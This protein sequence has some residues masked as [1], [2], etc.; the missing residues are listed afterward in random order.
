MKGKQVNVDKTQ[1]RTAMI[2][3]SLVDSSDMT[4]REIAERLGYGRPNIITMLKQGLVKIPIYRIP[5]IAQLFHVDAVELLKMAMEEYEPDKY[6]AIVEILGEPITAYERRLLQ[7]IREEVNMTELQVNTT[8][9]CEKIR[10][11]LRSS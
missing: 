2:F 4:Q 6:K 9:Y 7:V 3:E 11:C 5:K 10:A 8:H 1:S